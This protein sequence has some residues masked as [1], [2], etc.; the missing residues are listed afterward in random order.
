M[1][2]AMALLL[3]VIMVV[4][5]TAC[6]TTGGTETTG[7]TASTGNT[8]GTSSATEATESLDDL[9]NNVTLKINVATGNTSRTI[10]YN[11]SSPLTLSDGTVVSAGM[12]KPVW[13]YIGETLN[14][15]FED[16]T[17]QDQKAS[18]AIQ[19]GSTTDFADA[20]IYGGS[21]IVEQLLYYG[22]EGKFV[23]LSE[24]M[25]LGY[26]PN[27]AAY[28]EE[29]PS[30]KSAITA[31][32]GNIYYV[33]YIAEIGTFARTFCIR[34]SWVTA[35]LDETDADYDTTDFETYYEG[36]YI[37][38]NARTGDNGGS[39]TPKEGTTITKKTDQ[40]IIEIQNNLDVKNGE[41]LTTAFIQYIEDNYDY[42]DPSELFLGE[43]AAYDIDE[44]IALFRCIKANASYL[45]D[46]QTDTVWPLF[47]RQSSYREDLIRFATYWGGQQVYSS[48]TY[49]A[50]WYLDEDGNLQYS[51]DDEGIWNALVYLSQMDAEGLIY[52]DVYDTTNK[53]NHR[54]TLWGTDDSDS[55][56]YGFMTFDWIASSTADS[57][58][59]DTVVVLPPVAE[60]NGVWQ[61][62][63]E[64]AR[65][66][67]S[68][69]WAISVAG[70]STE[71]ELVRSLTLL[72]YFFS[73][74]GSTVQNY[75]LPMDYTLDSYEG[76]DG[77]L[78]PEFSDWVLEKTNEV[79][80]GDLSTFLR[81][82]MGS[83]LPIGYQKNIGFEYQ[84]T[85]DR[86]FEGWELLNNSTVNIAN[87][88]GEGLDG[89]NPYYYY[90]LPVTFS[91]TSRQQETLAE[92]TTI[93]TNSDSITEM[94]F[95]VVRYYTKGGAPD[96]ATVP[97]SYE[98]YAQIF[99]DM[100]IDT[101]VEIYQAAYAVMS[102][103]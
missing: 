102:A 59:E 22:T 10:T 64:N 13:S 24:Y 70:C 25:E 81:D 28:L 16:V 11:Q 15:T 45:T 78:Y 17:V 93:D 82:W 53:T 66:I 80:N 5:M 98:E 56:S 30:I 74:E 60:I 85:S 88:A 4:S 103:G 67:K 96:G 63:I 43:N 68:D 40:N 44:L 3:A 26:M 29:N 27:F 97:T 18:E 42:D 49:S 19:V 83:L 91:L 48:D 47:T 12:L 52:S 58:N 76:P 65:T 61:Y 79:A 39:V 84:Y 41:T 77:I 9:T 38:D 7:N 71:E 6:T 54:T 89:D 31:Y 37:G 35:L 62:Y 14:I 75:G 101:Y 69:G 50:T 95:N 20:N 90:L 21:S 57:L 2:K 86:G 1:K 32:D 92:Q 51:Y 55:P 94:M 23:N 99:A 73:D 87:Y 72:D 33:P 34:E 100:G 8:D 46:G 36:Y